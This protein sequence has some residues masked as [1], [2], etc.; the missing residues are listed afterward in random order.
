MVSCTECHLRINHDVV[1]S[2]RVVF[3]EGT[4]NY[5][6]VVDDDGLE[7]ILFP[8][9]VPVFVFR[10]RDGVGNG[11]IR[12]REILHYLLEG[13]FIKLALLDIG[14]HAVFTFHETF[15]TDIGGQSR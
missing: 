12:Y 9:F 8:F 2:L 7:E 11:C 6:A 14:L 3:V 1:F 13:C 5:T 10:F 4:V 15:E